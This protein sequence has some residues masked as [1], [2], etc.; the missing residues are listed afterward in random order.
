M[1]IISI[2]IASSCI[3]ASTLADFLL[4]TSVETE[5]AD[6]YTDYGYKFFAPETVVASNGPSCYVVQSTYWLWSSDD[7]SGDKWGV[8]F[9]GTV[10]DPH[11]VEWND[12]H[13]GHYSK[14]CFLSS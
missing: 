13:M 12:G 6:P 3:V 7:V 1:Q 8:R 10:N 5:P 9:E 14:S 2:L 4:F 11:V